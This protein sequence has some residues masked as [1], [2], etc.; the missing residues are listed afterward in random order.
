[1][2]SQ[3]KI[4]KQAIK[5]LFQKKVIY[6]VSS[7][8]SKRDFERFGIENWIKSGWHVNVFDIT[9]FLYP[10]YW[11]YSDG[12]NI[13]Y[14]FEGLKTFKNINEVLYALNNIKKKIIF[15]DY[16]QLSK[17]EFKIRK[18]AK[19]C[20]VLIKSKLGLYPTY[21]IERNIRELF[22]LIKNPVTL[23]HKLGLYIKYKIQKIR[24]NK[25]FPDYMV[26]GGN[27]GMRGINI[28]K[29]SVIKAHNLDYDFLIKKK[30]LS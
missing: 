21:K 7:P 18:V 5:G 8:F 12:K 22:S 6:L 3:S 20:G 11:K 4:K 9:S 25:Y 23:T 29:T 16:L 2:F 24:D 14:N 28:K 19:A 15:I 1:M 17:T 27:E 30:I 10:E 26:V 13:N